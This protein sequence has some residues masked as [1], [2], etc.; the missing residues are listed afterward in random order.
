MYHVTATSPAQLRRH[1]LDYRRT[2]FARGDYEFAHLPQ[3][4]YLW[5]TLASARTWASGAE[6]EMLIVAVDVSGLHLHRDP[7]WD[8]LPK[9]HPHYR[10]YVGPRGGQPSAFYSDRPIPA[11]RL[12]VFELFALA[13]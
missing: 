8:G 11:S 10:A 1:G 6:R 7:Y 4:N 12:L 3:G 9:R 13:A 2:G 5:P